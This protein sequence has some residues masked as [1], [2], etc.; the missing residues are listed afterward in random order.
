MPRFD[1]GAAETQEKTKEKPFF[2][3]AETVLLVE[4]EETIFKL[5]KVLLEKLGYT[6]LAASGPKETITLAE[7]Y[8]GK[9]DLLMTDV[10][11][12]DMSGK[13]LAQRLSLIKPNIKRLYMSGYIANVIA[14]Y[15][16]LEKDIKFIQKPFTLK[17]LSEKVRKKPEIQL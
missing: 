12:P 17:A 15:G 2:V 1:E 9:I 7:E 11:M 10:V 4:D 3:G 8:K 6:V 5:G 13:E 16:V 14:H